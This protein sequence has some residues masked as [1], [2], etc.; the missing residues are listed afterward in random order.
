MNVN[1]RE[2]HMREGHT[3]IDTEQIMSHIEH[4]FIK[5]T[6]TTQIYNTTQTPLTLPSN[7]EKKY[8]GYKE[9]R[10]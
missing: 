4:V 1:N 3:F 6:L 9:R 2:K 7:E 5:M 10:L 8:L